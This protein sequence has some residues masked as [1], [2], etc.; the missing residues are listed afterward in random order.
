M[1][2]HVTADTVTFTQAEAEFLIGEHKSIKS[3]NLPYLW[4]S[5]QGRISGK[6]DFKIEFSFDKNL[7][8]AYSISIPRI[9]NGYEV[10]LNNVVID[11]FGDLKKHGFRDAKLP[12]LIKIPLGLLRQ[13]NTLIIGLRSDIGRQSGLSQITLG[14]EEE[15]AAI[16]QEVMQWRTLGRLV[17]VIFSG[18]VSL[19]GFVL[20]LS[21]IAVNKDGTYQRD[22]IYFYGF[23]AEFALTLA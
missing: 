11:K 22:R 3:I 20:W 13:E 9:A 1:H 2:F 7:D 21:Q 16:Y 18:F 4:E 23:I 10:K 12:R 19:I 17:V 14:P 6:T 5:E 15:V 8:L